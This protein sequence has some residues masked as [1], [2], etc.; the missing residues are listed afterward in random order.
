[1]ASTYLIS[2]SIAAAKVDD[3][4]MPQKLTM[5]KQDKGTDFLTPQKLTTAKEDDQQCPRPSRS[6]T[7]R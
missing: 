6:D 3:L 7:V 1:M 4:L 2:K 5:A